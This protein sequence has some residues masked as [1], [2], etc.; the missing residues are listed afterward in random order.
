MNNHFIIDGNL[1]SLEK[2][3]SQNSGCEICWYLQAEAVQKAAKPVGDK[4]EEAV[5]ELAEKAARNAQ[6]AADEAKEQ[7][8]KAAKGAKAGAQSLG[9][10]TAAAA[11]TVLTLERSS[12]RMSPS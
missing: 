4:A 10:Q 11:D 2:D 7:V 1:L 8:T 12:T 5:Q 3:G 6:P 9:D